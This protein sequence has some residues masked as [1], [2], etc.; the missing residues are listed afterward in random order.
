MTLLDRT[1]SSLRAHHD[2]LADL[3]AALGEEQLV[4]P[5]GAT[6]W[7]LCDVLSHLGSGAEIMLGTLEGRAT[8]N[9]SVWAR[10]DAASPQEQ[11]AWFLE[12]DERL[13]AALEALDDDARENRT[14][15]LGFLPEPVG[16]VVPAGMRLNEA[17]HHSWDV[18]VGL[19]P[20]AT[21]D[22]DGAEIL[23]EHTAGP[24]GFMLGFNAKPDVLSEPA[25]V[26]VLGYGLVLEESVSFV[27]DDPVAPTAHLVAEPEAVVRL[28]SG[29]LRPEHTPDGVAVTG[30][31]G[32]AD[33]RRVFPGY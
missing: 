7:R 6:E 19:D 29:R 30:N 20:A 21:I 16:L 22:R 5:S 15:D 17:A 18:R 12:H 26:E 11:A 9:P 23:L 8:D 27:N 10:W 4:G 25:V 31:L 13:V 28:F 1:I 24:L 32:L 33:L 14:F 2:Q 3:L